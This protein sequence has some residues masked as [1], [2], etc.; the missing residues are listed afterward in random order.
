MDADLLAC[1]LAEQFHHIA[2]YVERP[3]RGGSGKVLGR[4]V[5]DISPR[6]ALASTA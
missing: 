3:R 2:R 6:K 5:N 1:P 4:H